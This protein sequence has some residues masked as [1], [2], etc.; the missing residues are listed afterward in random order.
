MTLLHAPSNLV[1]FSFFF[2]FFYPG[3]RSQSVPVLSLLQEVKDVQ[4]KL[5]EKEAQLQDVERQLTGLKGTAEKYDQAKCP[6]NSKL[7][8]GYIS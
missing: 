3:A 2:F 8:D 5:N 4:D 6:H 7:V 1:Y